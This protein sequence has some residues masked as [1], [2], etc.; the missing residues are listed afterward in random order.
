MSPAVKV[1]I[2]LTSYN[3]AKY[4]RE[5][6]ESALNQTFTEFELIIWDDGST[7]ESWKI[8]T[9]YTD[10]RISAFRNEENL[11]GGNIK[12][13]I[14]QVAGGEYI[15]VHHSDDIWETNKLQKQ[16]D[17]LDRHTNHGAV[18]T[19][20]E[21]I[22]EESLPVKGKDHLY[23]KLFDQPNRSRFDWLNYFF[24]NGNALCHPSVLIRASCF[25]KVHYRNGLGQLTDFDLWVQ[26]CLHEKIHILPEKLV[27]FR[28]RNDHANTSGDRPDTR[29]RTEF[30][31]LQVLEHFRR[32]PSSEELVKIFPQTKKYIHPK[33]ADI[34]Y[35]LGMLAISSGV[36]K[37]TRLFGLNLLFEVL[38]DPKLVKDLQTYHGFNK[39]A[40][41]ALTG[42]YDLFSDEA[43]HVLRTRLAEQEHGAFFYL[44]SKIRKV[45]E[46]IKN[47]TST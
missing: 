45:I 38:N 21:L 1:S 13:A 20:V 14:K 7:D 26:L 46:R 9:S 37:P 27:Q 28:I 5:A 19:H 12:R 39:K 18:F 30:E 8:I 44:I 24:F 10:P 41:V 32:I 4:I 16:V 25:A 42:K 47:L 35:P 34:R 43:L 23:Y 17:F 6:I 36:N 3:H 29:I 2:I 22:D 15:A 11:R 33:I 31:F 40:F